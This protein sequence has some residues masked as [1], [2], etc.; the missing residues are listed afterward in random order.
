MSKTIE[1][2]N[3]KLNYL[4]EIICDDVKRRQIMFK[5]CNVL[6]GV[7]SAFMTW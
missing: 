1:K 3:K 7:I 2:L 4:R 6:L 5:I